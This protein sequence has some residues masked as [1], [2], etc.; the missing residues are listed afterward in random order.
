MIWMLK[1]VSAARG[2]RAKY[3]Q[4]PDGPTSSGPHG[5]TK[6]WASPFSTSNAEQ[7]PSKNSNA[8]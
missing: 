4:Y 8:T 2:Q 6:Q 3:Q 1:D 7:R 5:R